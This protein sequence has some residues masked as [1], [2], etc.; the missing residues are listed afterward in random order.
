MQ[1]TLS[2]LW[3]QEFPRTFCSLPLPA[4][5]SGITG[6]HT[7]P[8]FWFGLKLFSRLMIYRYWPLSS[9]PSLLPSLEDGSRT[10]HHGHRGHSHREAREPAHL[11]DWHLRMEEALPIPIRS[12]PARH[13]RCESRSHYLDSESDVVFSSEYCFLWLIVNYCTFKKIIA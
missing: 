5:S 11:Q 8:G 10:V 4:L 3:N 2:S 1:L 7:I 9:L 6:V 13:P 12:S